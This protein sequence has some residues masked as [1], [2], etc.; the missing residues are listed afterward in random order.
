MVKKKLPHLLI[1]GGTG[2]IGYHVALSAKKKGWKVSSISLH[3]PKKNRYVSGVKY[4]FIDI[5]NLKKLK[6]GL[7]QSYTYVVN[8]GGYVQHDASKTEIIYKSH[9]AGLVNLTQIFLKK[10]IKKF[11]QIGT[12]MEYGMIQAP[13]SENQYGLPFS[14]YASAKLL[15]TNFLVKLYKTHRFPV[16]ILR[17]F[18][19]YGPEQDKNRILPQIIEGCL[20]NR[21]FPTSSGN[22]IRDFCYIDDVVRAIFLSF[23]SRKNNDGE[24]INIGNGKPLRV[25]QIIKIIKKIIGMGNPQFGMIKYRKDENMK[26]Y[27]NIKKAKSRLNWKPNFSFDKGI[28]IVIQSLK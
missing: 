24:I 12:S 14:T 11:I 19:V 13:Q 16:I 5:T 28:K 2:F 18:Q 10:K 17:L 26:L 8:L 1:I 20:K 15:S 23:N 22:Q 27:P 4:L 7:N 3:K 25:N 9:F 21:T 6:K